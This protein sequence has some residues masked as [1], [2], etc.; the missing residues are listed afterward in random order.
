M[1]VWRRFS[2]ICEPT[3]RNILS[4]AH[5]HDSFHFIIEWVRDEFV[6]CSNMFPVRVVDAQNMVSTLPVLF[7]IS[8]FLNKKL[9]LRRFHFFLCSWNEW[10]KRLETN[11]VPPHSQVFLHT[12]LNQENPFIIVRHRIL[13]ESQNFNYNHNK[14]NYHTSLIRLSVNFILDD[15]KLIFI[16]MA[17]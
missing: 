16:Q 4:K 12:I 5:T 11:K 14:R 3:T 17:S 6:K 10:S 7:I 2:H 15:N 9:S 1:L 8:F 13:R